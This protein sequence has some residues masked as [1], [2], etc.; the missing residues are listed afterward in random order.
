MGVWRRILIVSVLAAGGCS[1]PESRYIGAV[2]PLGN[3]P[4]IQKAAQDRDQRAVPA[5]IGQLNSDDP[6][7]RFYAIEALSS[8]TGQTFDYYYYETADE[9]RPAMKR[10]QQWLKQRKPGT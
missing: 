5:L 10:W 1:P 7:I 4:A 3:I 2:D 6:A 9:R 8:I